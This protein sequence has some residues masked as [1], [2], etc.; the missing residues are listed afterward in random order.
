MI[1]SLKLSSYAASKFS[2]PPGAI[3]PFSS[4][5]SAILAAYGMV[6]AGMQYATST[7][8]NPLVLSQAILSQVPNFVN[9]IKFLGPPEALYPYIAPAADVVFNLAA[10]GL[11]AAEA[12]LDM[13][14]KTE[15]RQHVVFLSEIS[16]A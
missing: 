6:I 4:Q 5:V 2:V 7:S 15:D 16:K 14:G 10:A 1:I 3:E 8:Q 9:P 11:L 12:I 13:E